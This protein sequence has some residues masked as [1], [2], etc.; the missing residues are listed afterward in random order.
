MQLIEGLS[1]DIQV[2]MGIRPDMYCP[3]MYGEA[4]TVYAEAKV[5]AVDSRKCVGSDRTI[6][7]LAVRYSGSNVENAICGATMAVRT[8]SITLHSV[9]DRII[10]AQDL[11]VTVNIYQRDRVGSRDNITL[12]K[13]LQVCYRAGCKI[14]VHYCVQ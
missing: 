11:N 8:S 3:L 14:I 5:V 9:L 13:E 1:L 6:D 7:P 10:H 2:D 12:I 4:C